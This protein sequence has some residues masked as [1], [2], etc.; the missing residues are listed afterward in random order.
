MGLRHFQPKKF[1]PHVFTSHSILVEWNFRPQ[2][3]HRMEVLSPTFTYNGNYIPN[4]YI[5]WKFHP[6]IYIKWK[7]IHCY[8]QIFIMKLNYYFNHALPYKG[9]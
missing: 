8:Y 2:H 1:Q 6:H 3:L 4:I 5:E 9:L 7:F